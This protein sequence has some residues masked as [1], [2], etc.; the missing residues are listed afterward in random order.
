MEEIFTDFGAFWKAMIND[1]AVKSVSR[2]RNNMH[3]TCVIKFEDKYK[4]IYISRF[5]DGNGKDCRAIGSSG[6][7]E[8]IVGF[9]GTYR[10]QA[11]LEA[12]RGHDS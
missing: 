3:G 2:N 6:Y 4:N 9:V 8:R 5:T 12:A 7:W 10:E 1:P 11:R